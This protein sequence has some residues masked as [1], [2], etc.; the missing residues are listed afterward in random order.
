MSFLGRTTPAPPS[1]GCPIGQGGLLQK[2]H[3]VP[4]YS[5]IP[6]NIEIVGDMVPLRIFKISYFHARHYPSLATLC[7]VWLGR[8]MRVNIL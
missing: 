7:Q 2:E 5:I 8:R 4:V 1:E 6:K 3:F